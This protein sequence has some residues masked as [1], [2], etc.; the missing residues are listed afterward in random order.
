MKVRGRGMI[1]REHS[2]KFQLALRANGRYNK[3]RDEARPGSFL[4][5][6]PGRFFIPKKEDEVIGP[7]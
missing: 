3:L 2:A 5:N 7:F 6:G 1:K 4:T